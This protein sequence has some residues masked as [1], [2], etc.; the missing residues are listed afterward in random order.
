MEK[1]WRLERDEI[2][3]VD[4]ILCGEGEIEDDNKV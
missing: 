4:A 2:G 1:Y 3:F